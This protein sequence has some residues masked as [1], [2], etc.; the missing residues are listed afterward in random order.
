MIDREQRIR[1][2]LDA[3]ARGDFESALANLD[4]GVEWYPPEQGTL[5]R[6]YR[7]HDEVRDLFSS[8]FDSWAS[9]T[10][11][12][13]RVEDVPA[14]TLVLVRLRLEGKASHVSLDEDWGYLTGFSEDGLIH[15]VRMFTDHAAAMTAARASV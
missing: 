10:H 7:G 13:V 11:D 3:I 1:D 9:I 6:V 5:A 4:P 12:Q 14:G 15:S 2:F 8:L